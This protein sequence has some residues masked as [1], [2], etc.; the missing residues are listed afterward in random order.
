MTSDLDPDR[1]E[2]EE[3]LRAIGG[4]AQ[5]QIDGLTARPAKGT[6]GQE[7]L[8]I[9]EEVSV[10]IAEDPLEGGIERI[11]GL[12]ERAVQASFVTPHPGYLAYVPG[13]GIHAGALADYLGACLNRFTGLAAEAPALCRLEADVI[14]WL[15]AELGLD[16]DAGAGG[17]FTSGGSLANFAAVVTARESVLGEGA[18]LRRAAA[19][20]SAQAHHSAIKACRLAG[21]PERNVRAVAVDAELRMDPGALAAAI[22]ADARGGLAPFLAISTAGTTGTGAIDPLTAIAALCRHHG[23]WHHVDGAYGAAFALCPEG[24]RA[25]EGIQLADS[26][27]ADPHKG[28][29]LPLGIGCLLARD[30][31]ALR[32]AHQLDADYLASGEEGEP[33][34]PAHLGPELSRPFRGLR[35]WLALMLHGAGAFREA[36]GEKL[37]LARHFHRE[38][39]RADAPELELLGPPQLSIVAFRL[40]RRA[41]EPLG[42]WN[43]RNVR[44]LERINDGGRVFLSKTRLPVADGAAE[45]LR[46]CALSFR[47][48]RPQIEACLEEIRRSVREEGEG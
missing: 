36:L 23:M 18:D 45:T 9:A 16:P 7:G 22:E 44:W 8:R 40:P 5:D 3:L 25:L 17:V 28:L 12:L 33:P 39:C 48:H 29:F 27:T 37:E 35:P 21:I 41:E 11:L 15:L 1:R 42:D 14:D 26:I 46:M 47:T 24:R 20:V 4:F 10:P 43:R 13:G 32:R 30:G 6:M 2:R 34:S 19:Y 38:L 31:E